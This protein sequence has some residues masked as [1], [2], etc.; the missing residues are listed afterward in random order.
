[1]NFVLHLHSFLFNVGICIQPSWHILTQVTISHLARALV[2]ECSPV[3]PFPATV[4]YRTSN[5]LKR[6]HT[7]GGRMGVYRRALLVTLRSQGEGK[8]YRALAHRFLCPPLA[9][10]GMPNTLY[11]AHRLSRP[12]LPSGTNNF[13]GLNFFQLTSC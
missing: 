2:S 7:L 12:L 4:G 6:T 8:G 13:T 10:H 1:M 5:V 9:I 3:T 11:S